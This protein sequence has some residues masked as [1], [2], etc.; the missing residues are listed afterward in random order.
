MPPPPSPWPL[1]RASSRLAY[2]F[3]LVAPPVLG[4]RPLSLFLLTLSIPRRHSW[5]T[6]LKT[7]LPSQH[8]NRLGIAPKL[9]YALGL[10]TF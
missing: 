1:P 2:P 9:R 10:T 6:Q 4:Q 5:T 7:H 3:L 8:S